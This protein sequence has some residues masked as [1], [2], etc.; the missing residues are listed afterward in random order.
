MTFGAHRTLVKTAP[1]CASVRRCKK[2]SRR[3]R[4]R[5]DYKR[6]RGT[7]PISTNKCTY[8]ACDQRTVMKKPALPHTPPR[9]ISPVITQ[10][11]A[12]TA[13]YL[14][15]SQ[16]GR[17]SS[18]Q[19]FLNSVT[20]GRQAERSCTISPFVRIIQYQEDRNHLREPRRLYGGVCTSGKAPVNFLIESLRALLQRSVFLRTQDNITPQ[21]NGCGWTMGSW[22]V[23]GL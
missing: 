9:R 12:R 6:S 11:N 4:R 3:P 18:P 7:A 17:A 13:S 2:P 16:R 22:L 23:W 8:E 21:F 14:S 19:V 5:V 20:C 10:R 15:E 1:T